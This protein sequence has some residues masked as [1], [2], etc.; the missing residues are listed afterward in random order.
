[1]KFKLNR[2][3]NIFN[4]EFIIYFAILSLFLG[5]VLFVNLSF[6]NILADIT[7]LAFFFLLFPLQYPDSFELKGTRLTYKRYWGY[8]RKYIRG[9][10]S[11]API[12]VSVSNIKYVE[13]YQNPIEKRFNVFR[14]GFD[15]DVTV[16]SEKVNQVVFPDK[17]KLYGVCNLDLFVEHLKSSGIVC[18]YKNN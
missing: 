14:I 18:I 6:A 2:Y 13:I 12:D 9:N 4:S 1:M 17:N 11:F 8:K 10:S 3:F 16:V 7:V 5:I 15:G